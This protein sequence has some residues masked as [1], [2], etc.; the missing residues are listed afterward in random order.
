MRVLALLLRVLALLW[1]AG[2][3]QATP[4]PPQH[5][6]DT[7]L[8]EAGSSTAVRPENLAFAPQY[9]LWSDGAAKRRWLYLPPGAS[10]DASRPDAWE[11]PPG[12]KAWKEFSQGRR[13]ETRLIER[14]PDGAWR[15]V[16]YVWNA[17]GT[18]AVLAPEAGIAALPVAGAPRGRYTIPSRSDCLACHEGAEVP[19]LGFSAL[20]LARELERLAASGRLRNLPA[21]LLASP[22]RIAAPS[23]SARAALGYLHAN[24]GHCHNHTGPL[25]ATG[26]AF[27]QQA[28]APQASAERTLHSLSSAGT[29]VDVVRRVRSSN[30]YVRMPPVGVSLID[31]KNVALIE[32]WI[33]HDL[34]L[35]LEPYP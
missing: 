16:A 5:L 25:A 19:L 17:E 34:R 33:R 20:Q 11:F 18:Q 24:C 1:L 15:F 2:A 7:G 8:F 4:P 26:L 35:P 6:D 3:A 22:P 9:E 30:P 23:E 12:T 21:S 29:S 28:A 27:A 31:A 13:V 32:S 10:I 14:L